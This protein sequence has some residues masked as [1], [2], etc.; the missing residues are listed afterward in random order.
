MFKIQ[1]RANNLVNVIK[2][3]GIVISVSSQFIKSKFLLIIFILIKGHLLLQLTIPT[4][5]YFCSIFLLRSFSFN[6]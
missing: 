5:S 4:A 3:G 1:F 6:L 2:R